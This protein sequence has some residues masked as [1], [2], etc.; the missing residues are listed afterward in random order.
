VINPT[1]QTL[2]TM[3]FIAQGNATQM[4]NYSQVGGHN[5]TAPNA[6]GVGQV[7]NGVFTST[8]ADGS[9]ISGTYSGTYTVLPNNQI[10]FNVRALWLSG[11]GRL[12][13]VTGQADVVALMN[14]TTGT[15]HYEDSGTWTLP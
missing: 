6:Q 13:G 11:T 7:V 10:R 8:A 12:A 2:G 1:A 4:G 14:A 9:T 5:F 3:K 15:F